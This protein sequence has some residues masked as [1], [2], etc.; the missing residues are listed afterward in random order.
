MLHVRYRLTSQIVFPS[1][2]LTYSC[3]CFVFVLEISLVYSFAF[4]LHRGLFK[5][6]TDNKCLRIW[7]EME[8]KY[9]ANHSRDY[10]NPTTIGEGFPPTV[11]SN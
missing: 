8:F 4:S 1:S 7:E 10:Y 2:D 6:V 11:T 5:A 3:Q 9:R